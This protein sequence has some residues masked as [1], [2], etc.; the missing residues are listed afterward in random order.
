MAHKVLS[1]DMGQLVKSMKDLQENY[2]SFLMD[3]YQKQML[4][5]AAIIAVNSKHLLEAYNKAR[6]LSRR[7]QR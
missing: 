4:Q 7:S 6:K 3:H 2:H 5:S 1:S